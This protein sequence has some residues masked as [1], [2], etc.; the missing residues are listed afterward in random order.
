LGLGEYFD[1]TLEEWID[2]RL[3]SKDPSIAGIEPP[4][5]LERLKKGKMIRA[6][7]PGEINHPFLDK[8]FRTPSGRIEFYCE[9][10]IPAGDA[11]PIFR[12][13]LESPRT[14]LVKKYPLVFITANNKFF[15]HTLFANDPL[16]L[17]SYI[18]EPHISINPQ[19][20]KKRGIEEGDIVIV[21]NDR[22]NCKV[23]A[24]ISETVPTGV[25][26]LPHG[27]WP[28]Q[29]IEGHLANLLLS[30]ASPETRD[31]AREIF[32]SV[33]AERMGIA[34]WSSFQALFAY[35]PDTLSDCLCEVKKLV[36]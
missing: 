21:Y 27:W 11:L 16:T 17:K 1:K 4:L 22:G 14:A 34:G 20:A 30:I 10:L 26:H 33:L 6:N 3:S 31:E 25:V 5:T 7:V 15:T 2:F 23:K 24:M 8:K 35:S 29:F 12:E 9:E 13:Q 19:D 18:S 36:I 28:K 32:W